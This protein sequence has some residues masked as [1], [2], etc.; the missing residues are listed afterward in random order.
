M[1]YQFMDQ[2]GSGFAVMKMCRVL[3]V[4]R[5]GYYSYLRRGLSP[6]HEENRRLLEKIKGIWDKVRGVYGSPRITAELR[7]Q[8]FRCGRNRIA[9]LMRENRIRARI[10][11]R[12]KVTTQ[13]DH[14]LPIAADLLGRDFSAQAPNEK[15]LSDITYIWTCEGWMYLAVVMD[16][17][18][19]EIVGWAFDDRIKKELVA[20][21]LRM[22]LLQRDPE[23]GLI[24]HSDRGSQYASGLVRKIMKARGIRPSMSGKGDCFDNAMMESFFSSLKKELVRLETFHSK[25]KA[26]RSVFEYIEIFYNR[27]RRHSA[28]NYRTPL[29]YYRETCQA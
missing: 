25:D 29:E 10:K 3:G 2:H 1:K 17:Y 8:G 11:K 15:W 23:P 27:Q 13:S 7:S 21:S 9:R 5:S 26:Y 28:L 18:N 12:F 20:D 22:A 19:R 6:R 16:V 24:F 14:S 4:S